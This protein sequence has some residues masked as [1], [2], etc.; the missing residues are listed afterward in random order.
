MV[1][2]RSSKRLIALIIA[3][4]NKSKYIPVTARDMSKNE[5]Q[6]YRDNLVEQISQNNEN[7]KDA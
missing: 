4:H 6:I 5:R 2:G 1:L 7:N 3:K